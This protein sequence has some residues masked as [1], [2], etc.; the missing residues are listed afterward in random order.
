MY[1]QAQRTG[2]VR[3]PAWTLGRWGSPAMLALLLLS[4]ILMAVG[5]LISVQ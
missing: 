5:S 4:L 1:R 3:D 2:P